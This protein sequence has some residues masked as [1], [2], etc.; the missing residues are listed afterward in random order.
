MIYEKLS[1][2]YLDMKDKIEI[3][4]IDGVTIIGTKPEIG[5]L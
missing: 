1:S 4:V 2:K 5:G 3:E